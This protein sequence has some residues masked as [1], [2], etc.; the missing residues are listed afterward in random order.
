MGNGGC[1]PLI[2]DNNKIVGV[3][4]VGIIDNTRNKVCTHIT[5]RAF[6]RVNESFNTS[7]SLEAR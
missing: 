3:I 4:M 1:S 7:V 5:V 6:G 2:R